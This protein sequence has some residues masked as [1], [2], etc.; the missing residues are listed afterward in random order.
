MSS[1]IIAARQ[2]D[3][4]WAERV[5]AS[6]RVSL[7]DDNALITFSPADRKGWRFV[8]RYKEEIETHECRALLVIVGPA[9]LGEITLSGNAQDP[10]GAVIAEAMEQ[11]A[12]I[13][14]V[15]TDGVEMPP[16]ELLPEALQ[17]LVNFS[18]F[19]LQILDKPSKEWK[20]QLNNFAQRFV[21]YVKG[22][23][24][25]AM[26][27]PP[28]KEEELTQESGIVQEIETAESPSSSSFFTLVRDNLNKYENILDQEISIKQ[29][30]QTTERLDQ[31]K[32]HITRN[33]E[34]ILLREEVPSFSRKENSVTSTIPEPVF[35]GAS[36]P[37]AVKPG[38]EFT[39]RFVAYEKQ[40]EEKIR[41]LLKKL[42]PRAEP[43][44]GVHEC[45][46]LHN[47][48][49]TVKFSARGLII[50]PAEQTFVWNGGSS[51]L[52][53]DVTVPA[54]LPESIIP[55]KFDVAIEGIVV[56]RL[57]LDLEITTRAI[58]GENATT[59]T[60]PAKTAFASYSSKDRL[61][62]LDRLAA[63]KISAGIDFFLDCLDLHPGEEWKPRLDNEIRQRE[64]FLLFWSKNASQ[65]KWVTWEL[66]TA[67]KE[68]GEHALQLHPLDPNI[69]PPAGLEKY[70]MSD[71]VMWV[72]K[73]YEATQ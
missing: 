64:L 23:I 34:N 48:S 21:P 50:D 19:E 29:S 10:I 42:S 36:A 45:R 47:T 39:A 8:P 54:D 6:F 68:K 5:A 67:L 3:K 73:G 65:S 4:K 43:I 51:L 60:E 30:G 49:V 57:R 24:R 41:D 28:E 14:P 63:V 37:R 38:D 1:I 22:E 52:E 2:G 55:L 69:N 15:L 62:V 53:F 46:W 32:E 70:H 26:A 72:R 31:I 56:A 17:P 12:I 13:V 27:K 44:L 25:M 33:S 61:R 9:L 59:T 7:G 16:W 20:E 11:D 66:E 18:S 71:V 35:L 40:L 58:A